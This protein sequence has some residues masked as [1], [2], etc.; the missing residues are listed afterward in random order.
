MLAKIL[1]VVIIFFQSLFGLNNSKL[2]LADEQMSLVQG[3]TQLSLVEESFFVRSYINPILPLRRTDVSEIEINASAAIAL[4]VNSEKILYQKNI[5]Q[6]FPIASLTKLMTAS[7]ILENAD[8]EQVASISKNAV[9]TYGEMGNLV[10]G[11]KITLKNLLYILLMESSNDAA[12][13][14]S[15]YLLEDRG[16][17][18]V[19]LMNEKNKELELNNTFFSDPSGLN[20]NNVS[21]VWDIGQITKYTLKQNLIWDILHTASIDLPSDN[22]F[23]HHLTNTNK[24]LGKAPE[25]I[26]GKT[27]YTEEAGGC[28][29][30]VI[31]MPEKNSKIILVI[32]G[33]DDRFKETEKL[34]EWVT[35]AYVF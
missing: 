13:A 15:E 28:M 4:D 21:S 1:A 14:L 11:K 26:G 30:A 32:L 3:K 19:S 29:I 25:M 22:G 7:V 6:K 18:L 9:N 17:D 12:V 5:Y 10:V 31:Q 23:N 2:P 27:G 16:L 20:K 8:L 24:L 34:I 33:T 35:K